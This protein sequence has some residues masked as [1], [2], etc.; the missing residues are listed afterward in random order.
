ML[1]DYLY[2]NFE[3]EPTEDDMRR[4]GTMRRLLQS[5][6]GQKDFGEAQK[7]GSFFLNHYSLHSILM[8]RWL[9]GDN[10]TSC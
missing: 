7:Q 9:A 8:M 3:V 2:L 1:H 10:A 4:G 6:P 5:K